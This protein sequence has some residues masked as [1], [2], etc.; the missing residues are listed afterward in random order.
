MATMYEV[1]IFGAPYGYSETIGVVQ[2]KPEAALLAERHLRTLDQRVRMYARGSDEPL[3]TWAICNEPEEPGA[4]EVVELEVVSEQIVD[5]TAGHEIEWAAEVVR[6]MSDDDKREIVE[7]G[8]A[9]AWRDGL[10]GLADHGTDV[11]L[12]ISE[13]ERLVIDTAEDAIRDLARQDLSN[14]ENDIYA[15]THNAVDTIQQWHTS[16]AEAGD[17]DLVGIIDRLGVKR[18]AEIYESERA[19][20]SE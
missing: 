13:I 20:L 5:A 8:N 11:G 2:S 17:T 4:R 19:T 6:S 15:H 18:A 10:S 3:A 9:D 7:I 12:V 14:S 1:L 16:A